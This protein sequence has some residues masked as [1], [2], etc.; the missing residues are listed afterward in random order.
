MRH[1]PVTLIG[2]KVGRCRVEFPSPEDGV[3]LIARVSEVD[4][5]RHLRDVFP[6]HLRVPSIAA[7]GEDE[8][9]ATDV[10][11]RAVGPCGADSAN[12]PCFVGEEAGYMCRGRNVDV[13]SGNRSGQCGHELAAGPIG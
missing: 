1:R 7:A 8:G 6:D 9:V 12:V 11:G 3:A 4:R 2:T 10:F 5:I 13:L